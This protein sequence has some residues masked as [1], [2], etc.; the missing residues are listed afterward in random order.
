MKQL[1]A[2]KIMHMGQSTLRLLFLNDMPQL[3]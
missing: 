1:V 3:V 2:Q